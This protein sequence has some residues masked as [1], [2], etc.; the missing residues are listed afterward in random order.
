MPTRLKAEKK[1]KQPRSSVT[2]RLV[3]VASVP[4]AKK[5]QK[6]TRQHLNLPAWLAPTLVT[7][8]VAFFGLIRLRLLNFPLERDEG[9]YAYAGQLIMHAIMPYRFCYSMKLPGTAAAYALLTAIF[10]Q[11]AAGVHLGLLLVN[12]A[13]TVL[14]YFLARRLFGKLA[15]V[16]ASTTYAFLS[17]EPTVLGFAGHATQF[18]VLPAVA[19]ILLLLRGIETEKLKFFFWSGVA[20]GLGFLMKQPGLFFVF[21]AVF[22][23]ACSEWMRGLQWRRLLSRMAVFLGGAAIP[24]VLT[25]LI[26][27]SA[28]VFSRFWFWTFSYAG[29]YG[30]IV[31]FSQGLEI[32]WGAV[33]KVVAPGVLIWIIAAIGAIAVLWGPKARMQTIFLLGFLLFSFAA[34]CPGFYFRQ[35][36]FVLLLPAVALSCGVAVS[37]ATTM[38][39]ESAGS[40]SLALLPTLIFFIALGISI[41]HDAEFFFVTDPVVACH[42]L[43]G[44]NPFPE[45]Q[46]I[47]DFIRSRA[48][49]GDRIVVIGSEPEIYFY[50]HLRSATGYVY[51]Y[52]LMEPQPFATSMQHEMESEIEG[53]MPRFV[54]FADIP[55]SWLSGPESDL[56]ILTWAE[57]FAKTHY[58]L[59]G[60][61]DL[62]DHGTEFHWDADAR[63]Y[64]PRSKTRVLVFQKS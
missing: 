34:V 35:H 31:T 32:F 19:G 64:K 14:I 53:V 42:N 46:Q 37:R 5:T 40:H 9:E 55:T 23:L 10:G 11:T 39:Q 15:G 16:T 2:P 12:S 3:P 13:T 6:S 57:Q 44:H 43:Y 56:G 52:P 24:F 49:S 62:L 17:L 60:V 21:F 27:V 18:V 59:V 61:V 54:V 26:M 58:Q 45:A 50:S 28:G 7:A 25:C 48:A 47:A 33:S 36:Y 4:P 41:L 63:S 1:S 29:Q 51:T 20:L 30:N 8:V 22:Y 38:I